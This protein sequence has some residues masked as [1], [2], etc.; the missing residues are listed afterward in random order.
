MMCPEC[1]AFI[2][3]EDVWC[4]ECDTFLDDE[5]DE[6]AEGLNYLDEGDY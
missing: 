2:D 3:E 5:W 4:P 6:D 1:G